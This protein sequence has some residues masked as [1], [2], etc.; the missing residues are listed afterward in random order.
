VNVESNGD[1]DQSEESDE[2]NDNNDE[3]QA[4][5]R[6]SSRR[7]GIDRSSGATKK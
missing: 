1:E 6:T 7:K 2:E 3:N 5:L 4:P